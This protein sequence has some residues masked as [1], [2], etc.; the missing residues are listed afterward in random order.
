R[1]AVHRL[2]KDVAASSIRPIALVLAASVGSRRFNTDLI[3]VAGGASLLLALL[4]VY[5]VT[6]FSMARR[7]PEIGIRLRLGAR[8]SQILATV[9][10]SEWR[11][12]ALGL[13]AG[14][15]GGVITGRALASVLFATSGVEPAV[16]FGAAATLGG[17]ALVASYLP[18]RR[19]VR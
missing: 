9:L 7:T 12:I 2:D 1:A 11:P 10:A 13:A 19:A 16:I 18:T 5:S 15:V 17:A 14:A 8:P 6:S 4:G 3:S